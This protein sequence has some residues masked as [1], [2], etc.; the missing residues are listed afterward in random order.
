MKKTIFTLLILLCILSGT[1]AQQEF[2]TE[3]QVEDNS[4]LFPGIGSKLYS[5]MG[6][7]R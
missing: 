4:L 3:W 6:R 7:G 1:N 5:H 2:I